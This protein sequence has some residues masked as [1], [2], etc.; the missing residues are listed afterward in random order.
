MRRTTP[1]TRPSCA[2]SSTWGTT[3][4]SRWSPRAWRPRPSSTSFAGAAATRC[5]DSS[6]APRWLP[7]MPRRCWARG[8]CK[9]R[10]R[11]ARDL[12]ADPLDEL[13]RFAAILRV[14]REYRVVAAREALLA[15]EERHQPLRA[16]VL[17]R[18]RHA[19]ERDALAVQR[20][21]QHLV[22]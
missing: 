20:R 16:H 19:P 8:G 3:S 15:P 6:S 12:G 10:S 11:V 22:V 9:L 21:V 5:R 7:P 4:G 18:E 17:S 1:R 13:A 2:P 14:A